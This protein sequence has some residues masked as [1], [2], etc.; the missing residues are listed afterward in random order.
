M[1]NYLEKAK[2]WFQNF[3]RTC[4]LRL[5]KLRAKLIQRAIAYERKK[6]LPTRCEWCQDNIF[7]DYYCG[8][9][10]KEGEI[11]RCADQHSER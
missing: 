9:I 1:K 11:A 8:Y 2:T 7:C 4:R 6:D 3:R 10:K 5:K